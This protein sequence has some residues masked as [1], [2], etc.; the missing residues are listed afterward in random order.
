MT[1]ILIATPSYDGRVPLRY[2]HRLVET[3]AALSEADVGFV[4]L[5]LSGCAY[6]TKARD[7][8]AAAFLQRTD[9]THLLFLDADILWPAKAPLR[10]LET[11]KDVVAG[12]YR[13]R[14]AP[15]TWHVQPLGD[16]RPDAAGLVQVTRVATGF[17]LIARPVL[18]ALS[19]DAPAYHGDILG[20][21]EARRI[22]PTGMQPRE[23]GGTDFVSEDF[24]F[25]DAVRA[26]GFQVWADLGVP[27]QHLGERW[28]DNDV[29]R[30]LEY[31]ETWGEDE[32]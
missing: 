26:A 22:F 3:F 8:L 2:A 7:L 5:D 30:L 18:E 4:A 15:H 31:A 17:M 10:L 19:K 32:R 9:C 13:G 1:S 28:I 27:I 11:R 23:D 6:L 25:C 21:V 24:V 12:V 16:E 20:G 29:P 14:V